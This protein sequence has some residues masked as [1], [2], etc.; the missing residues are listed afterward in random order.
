MSSLERDEMPR[1]RQQRQTPDPAA[2]EERRNHSQLM[3]VTARLA[4]AGSPAIPTALRAVR[5]GW[6]FPIAIGVI[7]G[8]LVSWWMLTN[9]RSDA[10]AA[11]PIA[12]LDA[13]DYHSL[14]IDPQDVD[15]VLFGSHSGIQE[16]RDGGFTW[17]TGSLLNA[18]AMIMAASPNA[19][20]TIYVA[21]HDVLQASHDG[22]ASWQPV[23]HNLPGTDIHGF[24]QSPADPQRLYAF[25]VGFG[26]LTSPDG[27][28]TWEPFGS[29]PPGSSYLVLASNGTD[30]YAA[31]DAGISKSSDHGASWEVLEEQPGQVTIFSLAVSAD[32][33][34]AIYAG[35]PIGLIRSR[36]GGESWITVGPRGVPVLAIAVTPGDSA[37]ILILSDEGSVY[38]SDDGGTTWQSP[39]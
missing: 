4:P 10:E 36:D 3:E 17:Q 2:A 1:K 18:D 21:G 35:T 19:P 27:G 26:G 29:Q 22:G 15:H 14:L 31:T 7:V 5:S 8:V 32:D 20:E 23:A 38:R 12:V 39:R 28:A 37:R 34:Q 16:S 25:V 24:A 33:P 9:S 11:Q 6:A 13:P 30:L